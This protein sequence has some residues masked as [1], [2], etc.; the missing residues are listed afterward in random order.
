[1]K[2]KIKRKENAH[3]HK[4]VVHY[5]GGDGLLALKFIRRIGN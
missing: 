5:D 4:R 1:M 3:I 2:L